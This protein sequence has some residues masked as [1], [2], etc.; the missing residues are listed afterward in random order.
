MIL[1]HLLLDVML[2][3]GKVGHPFQHL[4]SIPTRQ[5][6]VQVHQDIQKLLHRTIWVGDQFPPLLLLV[7]ELEAFSVGHLV[8]GVLVLRRM[9]MILLER[10]R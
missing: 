5:I 8:V 2:Y 6:Q 4:N 3:L 9:A 10:G 1:H 7:A